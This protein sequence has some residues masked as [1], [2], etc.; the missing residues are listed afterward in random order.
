VFAVDLANLIPLLREWAG[1]S[2]FVP[3]IM[4][5]VS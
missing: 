3:L 5:E 1:L 2:N 4:Y